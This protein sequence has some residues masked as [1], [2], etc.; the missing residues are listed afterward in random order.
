MKTPG[1]GRSAEPLFSLC[2][3]PRRTGLTS[4]WEVKGPGPEKA[5][6]VP[7]QD[8]F[9][10]EKMYGPL[11]AAALAEAGGAMKI[12]FLSRACIIHEVAKRA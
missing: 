9:Y 12:S 8:S 10:A 2:G 6:C 3:A 7:G 4:A 5:G 11:S 1:R